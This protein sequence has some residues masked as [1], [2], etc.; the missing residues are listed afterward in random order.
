M[1]YIDPNA[2]IINTDRSGDD[3][4]VDVDFGVYRIEIS[5]TMRDDGFFVQVHLAAPMDAWWNDETGEL[6]IPREIGSFALPD[7][8]PGDDAFDPMAGICPSCQ[9]EILGVHRH[10]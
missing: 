9:R 3:G 10:D 5:R 2:V 7:V 6:E 4:Q 8:W 1:S